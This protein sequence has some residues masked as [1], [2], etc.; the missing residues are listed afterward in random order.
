MLILSPRDCNTLWH[1]SCPLYGYVAHCYVLSPLS[2]CDEPILILSPRICSSCY[3]FP[4]IRV[5][6]GSDMGQSGLPNHLSRV[7]FGHIDTLPVSLSLGTRS[8]AGSH[9]VLVLG[10]R[11][12]LSTAYRVGGRC[13]SLII[14][15][16]R[17]TSVFLY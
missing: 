3:T 14:G 17:D 2:R 1:P 7:M 8:T 11:V 13:L 12:G 9:R 5:D 15:Y 6:Y 4:L 16:I 10:Y